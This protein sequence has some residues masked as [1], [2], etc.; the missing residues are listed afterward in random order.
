MSAAK[1]LIQ[2]LNEAPAIPANPDV[3]CRFGCG[4]SIGIFHAP[5]GCHCFPDNQLMALCA[6]HAIGLEASDLAVI[7]K[8]R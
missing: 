8:W 7:A 2:A 1:W 5:N 3:E 6:Q 4:P